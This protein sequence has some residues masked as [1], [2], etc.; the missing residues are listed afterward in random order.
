[1]YTEQEKVYIRGGKNVISGD[2]SNTKLRGK[3]MKTVIGACFVLVTSTRSQGKIMQF[4]QHKLWH[5]IGRSVCW[6]I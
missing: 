4:L 6:L 2:D 5:T 1:M 3:V